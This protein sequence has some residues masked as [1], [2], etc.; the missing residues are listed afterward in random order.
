MPFLP[1]LFK[2]SIILRCG[3]CLTGVD[4]SRLVPGGEKVMCEL[5]VRWLQQSVKCH[6]ID[7]M[8]DEP[9]LLLLSAESSLCDCLYLSDE[10]PI[11]LD[12]VVR[13]YRNLGRFKQVSCI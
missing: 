10:S 1:Y 3:D 11:C 6:D 12:S 4:D 9:H 5:V 7:A 2:I 8:T 13:D